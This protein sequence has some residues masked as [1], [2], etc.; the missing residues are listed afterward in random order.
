[1]IVKIVGLIEMLLCNYIYNFTHTQCVINKLDMK[2]RG[3][4]NTAIN[5]LPFEL[6]LPGYN[7][8]GPGTKLHKRLLRGDKGVNALDNACMYHDIAYDKHSNI[9]DRH[10]ADLELYKMAKQRLKSKD[11]GKG[12]K[13]ASWLVSKVMKSKIRAGAGIKSFKHFVGKIRSDLKKNKTKN[14]GN[15]I[16]TAYIIAKK[17]FSKANNVRVPRLIP[18]PKTGGILPLIPIF[19]GLSALG[20]LAGGAAGIAKVIGGYKTA[21][22]NLA[23]SERHNKMMESIALGKGL[24]LKPYRNGKGLCLKISKN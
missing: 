18:I 20:S 11:A 6:H 7:Y 23:E 13:L 2:G 15:A 8:C 22:K 3:L 16:N 17:V 24:H 10:S 5:N 21:S 14:K 12:E 19:A 4:L 9:K 1:M